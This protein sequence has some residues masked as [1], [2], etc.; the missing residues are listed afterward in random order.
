[1]S[2]GPKATDLPA[3]PVARG[4]LGRRDAR[5]G[6]PKT[7]AYSLLLRD[8]VL[9]GGGRMLQKFL[10]A[11]LLPLYTSFLGPK[12]YGVLG[13]VLVTTTLIDVVVVLGFD[14]AFTRFYFDDKSQ[15]HRDEVITVEFWVS[16]VYPAVLLGALALFMPQ[17]S[18]VLMNQSGYALY[19]DLGLLNVFFT[20]MSAVP[21]TLYR[22]EHKP[23]TFLAFNIA[24]ILIQI[25]LTVVL[26]VA[27]H[28]G[29]MGVLIGNV[30][31][32]FLLNTAAMPSYWHHITWRL[33]WDLSKRM[34]A[35][36]VPAVFS[37]LIFFLLKLSD[38]FFLM[39]YWGKAEVGVYTAA[40]T[41]SQPVYMVMSAFRMAWPQWHFAKLHEPEK[42]K[43]MVARSS[44]YF[45]FFCMLMLVVQG[46]WM[47]LMVRVL[48]RNQGFWRAGP[49][50][51]ILT[52]ATVFYSAYFVFWVGSN[53]AKK[54]RLVPLVAAVASG[55][56][57]G[58]NLLLI[59]HFGMIAAAWTTFAGYAVL[60][61]LIY[62]ISHRH[63]PIPYEWTR[64]IKMSVAAGVAL[65]VG[66]GIGRLSG[67]SVYMPF[68]QLVVREVA[69]LPALLVFFGLLWATR[70]FTPPEVG[71][72]KARAARLVGRGPGRVELPGPAA[73]PAAAEPQPDAENVALE[74][75]EAEDEEL[76]LETEARLGVN[77]SA[78]PT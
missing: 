20:N 10:S 74:V 42:H 17:I 49:T 14:I 68:G 78:S 31:T 77:E 52:A 19:F 3:A 47:P 61:A 45:L 16:T 8:S 25:P 18:A 57:V 11:M 29:V 58:F 13:M 54:N 24:R 56:N 39:R 33:H 23:Y 60:A 50:A 51:L 27:F 69:K 44:T 30:V 73:L 55:L 38:R 63:Y 67:E 26:V 5:R 53:V 62:P 9:Y 28:Q 40:F 12:D 72:L 15:R 75:D 7:G 32:S 64:L 41:I 43:R 48:L 70:F 37:G 36:A 59:P 21:F 66:W 76:E 65:A 6:G 2:D 71:A 1:V 34:T 35:F 46:I 22:L 4:R